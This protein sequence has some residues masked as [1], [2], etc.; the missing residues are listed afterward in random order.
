MP[1]CKPKQ[2]C[3]QL[4]STFISYTH[5]SNNNISISFTHLCTGLTYQGAK[6][7]LFYLASSFNST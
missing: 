7:K 4:F 3:T 1:T 6:A 2:L 5:A